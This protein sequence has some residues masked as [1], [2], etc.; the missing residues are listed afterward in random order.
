MNAAIKLPKIKECEHNQTIAISA[1]NHSLVMAQWH[2]LAFIFPLNHSESHKLIENVQIFHK[3]IAYVK[4]LESKY[5]L[6]VIQ[7]ILTHL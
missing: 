2:C 7:E 5:L 1:C 4:Q 3:L 6:I